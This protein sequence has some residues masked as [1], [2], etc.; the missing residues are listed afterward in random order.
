MF[1]GIGFFNNFSEKTLI[2]LSEKLEMFVAY[3]E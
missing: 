1:H 2:A 3:P